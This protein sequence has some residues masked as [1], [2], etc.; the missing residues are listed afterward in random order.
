MLKNAFILFAVAF[1]ILLI[2]LPLFSRV[3]DVKQKDLNYKLQIAELEEEKKR[4]EKEKRLLEEDPVYLEKV[5]RE[6][7]G[8]IR[9]GEAVY[10]S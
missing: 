10:A 3:Q 5:A 8:L 7:M 6:K 2:F 4:L 9:E 1:V